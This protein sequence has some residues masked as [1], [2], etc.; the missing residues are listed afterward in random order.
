MGR[1][2]VLMESGGLKNLKD[3]GGRGGRATSHAPPPN[4]EKPI[5]LNAALIRIVTTF[6]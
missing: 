6:Y 2:S 1:A 3:G 4:F 5:P